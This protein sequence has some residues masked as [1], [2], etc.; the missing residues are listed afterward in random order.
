MPPDDLN[1]QIADLEADLSLGLSDAARA[2]LEEKLAALR[3]QQGHQGTFC[4][5]PQSSDFCP[6]LMG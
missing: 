4:H 2:A 3:Q 5:N 6:F 1:R